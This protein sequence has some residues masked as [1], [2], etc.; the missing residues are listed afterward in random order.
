M[1]ISYTLGIKNENDLNV[2]SPVLVK[3]Q[4][5]TTED[6]K[7]IKEDAPYVEKDKIENETVHAA[8]VSPATSVASGSSTP[9]VQKPTEIITITKTITTTK[10][11]Q[12]E[13]KSFE[14]SL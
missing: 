12:T 5:D 6:V 4:L 11:N 7:V 10:I 14:S 2:L 8:P 13:K 3:Y 1:T 9:D